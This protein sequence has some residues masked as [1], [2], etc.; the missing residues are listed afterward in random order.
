MYELVKAKLENFQTGTDLEKAKLENSPSVNHFVDLLARNPS[1]WFFVKKWIEQEER[2]PLLVVNGDFNATNMRNNLLSLADTHY[3]RKFAFDFLYWINELDEN[4]ANQ[5]NNFLLELLRNEL[6]IPKKEILCYCPSCGLVSL[7]LFKNL[8]SFANE[9]CQNCRGVRLRQILSTTLNDEIKK[10]I[11]NGQ[12]L[13]IYINKIL[14]KE[15]VRF[16]GGH[17]NGYECLT[18]IRYNTSHGEGE[19]DCIGIVRNT[20]IFIETKMTTLNLTDFKK[21]N[22]TFDDISEKLGNEISN[23]NKLKV[24]VAFRI[25]NHIDATVYRDCYFVNLYDKRDIAKDIIDRILK[26]SSQETID[27]YLRSLK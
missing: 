26:T 5:M 13:E 8:E 23:L 27:D 25:D 11:W 6:L 3:L 4:Q 9:T 21:E 10:S 2:T 24:F 20:V 7:T 14:R 16:I 15:G 22:E 12:L 17:A 19:V 1:G 18:S